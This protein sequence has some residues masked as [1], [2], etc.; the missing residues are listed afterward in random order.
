MGKIEETDDTTVEVRADASVIVKEAE[1]VVVRFSGDSG[2]GM[3]LTGMQFSD[4]T[5]L[6]GNDLSTFPDYPSEIRAPT[7]TIAGVSGF[8]VHFGS[9]EILTPGDEY[10]I[11]VVMNAAALKVD[12]ARLKKG[13][14]IVANTA[15]FDRKNLG[16]AHYPDGV[17]PLED[18]SLDNFTVHKIDVT[19]HTKD[20]LSETGLGT[21]DIER[22]KNMFILGLLL[23][24]FDKPLDSTIKFM[25][26][27]FASK[28]E[29]RDANILTLRAGWNYGENTEIFNTR[30]KVNAAKLPKGTYRNITG[31]HATAIG[32]IAA[33][34]KSGLPLFLG[35]YPITPATDIFHELSKYKANNV[36]TFQA[37]DEIAGVC[38][39]IGA[40]YAGNLA[41]TTTSGP[42]LA[43]KTEAI[44]LATILEIPLVIVNVQRGGPS[45]GLPT[46]TEQSD[47]LMAMYG[48]HGEAPLPVIAATS[49]SDCFKMAY[50]ACRIAVEHMTPVIL[51]TDGYIANGSEPWRFP[52]ED[53]LEPIHFSFL[54][55][56]NGADNVLLPYKRNENLVRPW[57]KP[58]TKGLEHRIGGLEKENETGNVSYEPLNHEKM[59][60]LRAAKIEKIADCIPLAKVDSGNEKAKL[61]VMGWGSTYGAIKTAVR[62]S[63][64]MGYDVAHIHLRYINPLPK[65]LG[66]LLN[67]FD[68]ILI[69]EM[70]SGQLL[71]I[72][73]AK[74]LL[75]AKGLSKIQGLPY[76]TTELKAKI[77]EL[78]K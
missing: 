69:P 70:N 38:S 30:Y 50:E 43:L 61:L 28:P 31:N 12:L 65:N 24:M 13:G 62:E 48:R 59:V 63:L 8:Q 10:D 60:E 1:S 58:G 76:T 72:I 74:Y 5:A 42:G 57:I 4:T 19:K 68:Q 7:G 17:N 75:P 73:R 53:Q 39:A 78:L 41:I 64:L 45:T 67:G 2:D 9:K 36:K 54:D 66:E 16:L 44:G 37:E 26:E 56:V 40:S 35:S 46:K 71:Q 6:L 52:T 20:C 55:K 27:K 11:L 29:I 22:S 47:L 23:W 49:P 33:S 18:G 32:L 14:V 34:E 3:Q 77:A 15:G 25:G 21:K 51:L